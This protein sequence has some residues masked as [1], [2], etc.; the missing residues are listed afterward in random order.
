MFIFVPAYNTEV[1]LNSTLERIYNVLPKEAEVWVIDDASQDRTAEIA[2]SW[3]EKDPRFFVHSMSENQ[4]YGAV[5]RL[6]LNKALNSSFNWAICIHGD[7]QYP[8]EKIDALL[9][10]GEQQ[11]VALVIGSRMSDGGKSA[12]KG[13]MPLY[14]RMANQLLSLVERKVLQLSL[15]EFHSGMLAY[16]LKIWKNVPHY[17]AIGNF[18]VDLEWMALVK[19]WGYRVEEVAIPTHYG[20]EISH[21]P[22]VEY[23]LRCLQVLWRYQKGYYVK[24]EK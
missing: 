11:E 10:K 24:I 19:A 14:K 12:R 15:S 18:E 6:A 21:V 13:G 23:G 5:V 7:G 17:L 1:F 9:E 3:Q 22:S 4:G 16:D 20:E 2:R 8:P